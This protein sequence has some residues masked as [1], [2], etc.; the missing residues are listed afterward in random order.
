MRNIFLLFT[1]CSTLCNA[2]T[3]DSLWKQFCSPS[4]SSKTKVWWFHGET[5]TTPTGT[6]AD[7]TAYKNAGIGGVVYYDQTHGN[8][9]DASDVFSKA[10][11]QELIYSAQEAKRLG[12][13][14]EMNASNGYVAGGPWITPQLGMQHIVTSDT[15]ITG[16]TYFRAYL[17]KPEG[18]KVFWDFAVV[19]FPIQSLKDNDGTMRPKALCNVNGLHVDSLFIGSRALASVPRQKG[20][21]PVLITL[22]YGKTLTARSFTYSLNARAKAPNC[23]MNVP[24]HHAKDFYGAGFT[25]LPYAGE[26]EVSADGISYNKVCKIRPLYQSVSSKC[27]EQ[28][29]SFGAVSGRYFRLNLH[30]WA[31]DEGKFSQLKIGNIH[32]SQEERIDGWQTKTGWIP[33]FADTTTVATDYHHA[34]DTTKIVNLTHQMHHDGHLTWKVPDGKWRIIRFAYSP[35]G[36]PIKH[37]R[38]GMSGLECDKMSKE[39][40]TVQFNN[41]FGVVLDT[42]QKYGCP[43]SGIT[44]DSHEAGPQ[45]WT[46]DFEKAFKARRGY[47]IYPFLPA[48]CGY[49]VESESQSEHFLYDFRR[50]IA[51]L[52][53]DNYYATMDSISRSRGV[54]LTGQAVGN[55]LNID[56]DNIQAKGKVAKPQGEFWAYQI[57]GSYDIKE[58]ASAAHLYGKPIA[59]AEAFTDA[60]YAQSPEYLKHLAD[61]AYTTGTN[62]FVVCA[63]AY[64]P[65]TDKMPGNT[66]GGREYGL[67]RNNTYWKYSRP[68][69]DYQSRCAGILRKGKPIVDLCVY[70][71]DD[72]PVKLLANRLPEIPEGYN[73]DVTTTDA[74]LHMQCKDGNIILPDS[75]QYKALIIDG[76]T[77]IPQQALKH[78]AEMVNAGILVYA[79]RQECIKAASKYGIDTAYQCL[80]DSLWQNGNSINRPGKGLVCQNISIAEALKQREINPDIAIKSGNE[81]DDKVY[82]CHRKYNG[83]DIYFIYNH[84]KKFFDDNI[85]LNTDSHYAERWNPVDVTRHAVTTEN[86]DGKLQLRL[87]LHPEESTFLITEASISTVKSIA[88]TSNLIPYEHHSINGAWSVYFDPRRG[89]PGNIIF[90]QLADW[91]T[92]S[93]ERIKYYSGEAVYTK[94][95]K[96]KEKINSRNIILHIDSICSLAKIILNGHEVSTL[97]CAPWETDITPYVKRGNNKLEIHVVNALVNR[98]IGDA[99]LPKEKRITYCTTDIAKSTDPLIPSGIIGNVEY[100]IR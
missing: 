81:A 1:L 15:T 60:K 94:E 65:W 63:S 38:K 97:W 13:T 6:T 83:S 23:T 74:L 59:S 49:V 28:T 35:T 82:F 33:D 11:W 7:L 40:T 43:P 5:E 91:T 67:S 51:D 71:G 10:W 84:S 93:D 9:R 41:Y 32:I 80:I 16:G 96:V 56:G 26:L 58:S 22:D 27:N 34:I 19:A 68:F 46:P 24:G 42:L 8:G 88:D 21:Q 25:R 18:C 57:N 61:Y 90:K 12:L 86:K 76:R 14:F 45:N 37:G 53:S 62:E 64:Q 3:T 85:I 29:I 30:D 52:I 99:S 73:F 95:F 2:S 44:M 48:L 72:A 47:D 54:T 55:A 75:M 66:A 100:R 69:W 79:N 31:D 36:S 89:G 50:T 77:Y 98:M 92:N 78:I 17:P 4:D 20:G 87:T 39:A 70:L